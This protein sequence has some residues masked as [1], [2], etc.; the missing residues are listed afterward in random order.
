VLRRIKATVRQIVALL[1][2]LPPLAGSALWGLLAALAIIALHASPVQFDDAKRAA[3]WRI[4]ERII[5]RNW[6][7]V[8][9]I[10]QALYREG[11]L[12]RRAD[13]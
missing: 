10:A 1:D 9:L 12:G 3:V 8:C 4:T 7:A 2:A 11:R 5:E 13:H 6:A